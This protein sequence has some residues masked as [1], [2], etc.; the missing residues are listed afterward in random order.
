MPASRQK[1]LNE[2]PGP[3]STTAVREAVKARHGRPEMALERLKERGGVQDVARNGGAWS[4]RP[5][6]ARYWI[7]SIHATQTPPQLFGAGS[8]DTSSEPPKGQPRPT[9]PPP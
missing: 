3:H 7:A 4:G 8:G 6:V 9:R 5:G 2:H 1:W